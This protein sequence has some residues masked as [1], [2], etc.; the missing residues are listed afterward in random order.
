MNFTKTI[1]NVREAIGN[2]YSAS[3]PALGG[4]ASLEDIDKLRSL[5]V[6]TAKESAF[7]KVVQAT[8]IRDRQHGPVIELNRINSS[9]KRNTNSSNTVTFNN[10]QT[11][12]AA[13]TAAHE[14]NN[15]VPSIADNSRT[16]SKFDG[17]KISLAG[18]NA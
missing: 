4:G 13:N 14:L 1:R 10:G 3:M 6:S 9:V 7:R 11:G 12:A 15:T 18:C 17:K 8:M 16:Q 5:L 2:R